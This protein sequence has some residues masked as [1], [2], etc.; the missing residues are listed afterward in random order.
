M[1]ILVTM[2]DKVLSLGKFSAVATGG[3]EGPCPPS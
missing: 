1:Q 3:Q 2:E